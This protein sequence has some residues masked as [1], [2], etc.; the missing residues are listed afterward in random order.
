MN[1]EKPSFALSYAMKKKM[2]KDQHM[3]SGGE[4]GHPSHVKMMSEGGMLTNDGYQSHDKPE[5][6][7]DL[8]PAAHLEL[9]KR[10]E[11]A[12]HPDSHESHMDHPVMNQAGDEDEGAGD[13]DSIHPMVR[14]IM[15]G[16]AK[17]YSQGGMVANEDQGESASKPVQMAK[18]KPNEFDDL[19][20]NDALEF[21]STGAN[22][23]DENDDAR[24]NEDRNDIVSRIMKS[25]AKKDRMAV[26]G[27]GS[28]YGRR[29]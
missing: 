16:M 29:K 9:E 4:C 28:S 17:G 7:G 20:I 6:Y 8:M 10:N 26:P 19:A 22:A 14:R 15:M 18:D 11:F 1:M 24:E 25:R 21:K 12:P 2:G 3:C 23:G 5:V 13:M 27:E